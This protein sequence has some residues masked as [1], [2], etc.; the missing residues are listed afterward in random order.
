MAYD[1]HGSWE[2]KLGH[3][4][5]FRAHKNDP[6]GEIASTNHAV[7]YWIG[8]GLPAEKLVYGMPAYGRCFKTNGSKV[9]D[10]ATGA[11]NA[12]SYTKEAG[13]L[14]YYEICE[15]IENRN[16]EVKY[17]DTMKAPFAWGDGQ[18]CGYNNRESLQH[19]CTT[20]NNR[21]YAGV[22]FWD[23]SLDDFDNKV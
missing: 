11:S 23:T 14:S 5:Q 6:V 15:K 12:G 19:R 2:N 20:I 16:W 3:H 7:N 21:N 13:F 10:A 9:G 8:K 18:W 1:L 17:S 4:S 22:M